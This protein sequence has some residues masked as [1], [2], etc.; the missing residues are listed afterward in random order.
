MGAAA[1]KGAVLIV[2]L[3]ILAVLVLLAVGIGFRV[4]L[5]LKLVSYQMKKLRLYYAAKA[6]V[7]KAM[8]LLEADTNTDFDTI[9]QCGF[10]LEGQDRRKSEFLNVAV[11]DGAF[12]VACPGPDGEELPGMRD[13]DRLVNINLAKKETL[14]RLPDVTEA[15]AYNIMAW[16]GDTDEGI[17]EES[18]D[19]SAIDRNYSC[20]K[21]PFS[22]VDELRLVKGITPDIFYGID[23][24]GDGIISDSES[25]LRA[26]VTIYGDGRI[27]INT[28]GERVLGIL[29]LR[30]DWAQEIVR[31]R[32]G[33]D[34]NI[35]TGSDNIILANFQDL[36]TLREHL[37][38]RFNLDPAGIENLRESLSTDIFKFSSDFFSASS[39]AFLSKGDS[40]FCSRITAVLRRDTA[41]APPHK[42]DIVSWYEE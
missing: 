2:T 17:P 12:S 25:G 40:R 6:G 13:E 41:Q 22:T 5:E 30:P 34:G 42:I 20:K 33:P 7:N 18:F 11:G 37:A 15:I 23:R 38:W 26:L 10:V 31:Y 1:K 21:A 32:K 24:D 39:T 35:S 19:Y 28:A 9:E 8:T 4:S 27:N 16:R 14:M 36:D 29:G 3:W